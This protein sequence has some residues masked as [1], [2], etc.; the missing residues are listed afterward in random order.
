MEQ[1]EYLPI[2]IEAEAKSKEIKEFLKTQVPDKK[3]FPR[4]MPQA[5]MPAAAQP[6]K[7]SGYIP[8]PQD[9]EFLRRIRDQFWDERLSNEDEEASS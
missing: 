1:W 7:L 4:Y 2:H 8:A 5:M 9:I 6:E 3:R